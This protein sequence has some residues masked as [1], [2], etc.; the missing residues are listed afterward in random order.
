MDYCIKSHRKLPCPPLR[1]PSYHTHQQGSSLPGGT[2][3]LP[4]SDAGSRNSVY[5]SMPPPRTPREA[6]KVFTRMQMVV[7]DLL[8]LGMRA[9][10]SCSLKKSDLSYLGPAL[11]SQERRRWAPAIS[12]ALCM[13][14]ALLTARLSVISHSLK[15]IHISLCPRSR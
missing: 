8:S 9:G 2:S 5:C 3:S 14:G 6:L 1:N 11:S 12:H 13:P 7:K 10:I 4:P 15:F